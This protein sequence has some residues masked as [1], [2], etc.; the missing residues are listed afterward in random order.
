M[1]DLPWHRLGLSVTTPSLE[2]E[3]RAMA[4]G[5]RLQCSHRAP[6]ERACENCITQ[7]LLLARRG[8]F[9]EGAHATAQ[10]CG[11]YCDGPAPKNPYLEKP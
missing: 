2:A 6:G 4:K 9:E 5:L 10:L 3:A 1:F 7:A 8:A 11:P